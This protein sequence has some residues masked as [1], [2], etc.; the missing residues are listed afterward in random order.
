MEIGTPFDLRETS[1]RKSVRLKARKARRALSFV[2]K[3]PET[4]HRG[5]AEP[6]GQ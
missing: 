1:E 6:F 3:E 5:G 2:H 4:G